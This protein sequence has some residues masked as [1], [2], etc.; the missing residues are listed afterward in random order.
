MMVNRKKE[1]HN[2]EV[3]TILFNHRMKLT[4]IEKSR[5]VFIDDRDEKLFNYEY[6]DENGNGSWIS[7][8]TLMNYELGKNIPSL[9][10]LKRLAAAYEASVIELIKEILPYID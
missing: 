4:D 1:S 5:K 10:Y 6:M 7:E 8:K 2:K 3:G 9:K